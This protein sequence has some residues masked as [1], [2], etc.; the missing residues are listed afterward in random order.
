METRVITARL[1]NVSTPL[2]LVARIMH[3]RRVQMTIEL[4]LTS[5]SLTPKIAFFYIDDCLKSLASI[6]NAFKIV[7][8]LPKLLKKGEFH[9]TIWIS[10]TEWK[11]DLQQLS[12]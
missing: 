12:T 3:L 8:E 9:F 5:R 2:R 7:R 11:N 1:S 6:E 4:N 10:K